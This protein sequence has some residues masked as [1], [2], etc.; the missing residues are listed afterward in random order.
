ML[1]SKK[2]FIISSSLFVLLLLLWGIYFFS[3]KNNAS[4]KEKFVENI[5]P[6]E[7][8]SD[9]KIPKIFALSEEPVLGP[10]F[11]KNKSNLKYYSKKTG[12]VFQIEFDGSEKSAISDKE[13]SGLS[14]IFWSPEKN[15]VVSEFFVEGGLS[16]SSYDYSERMGYPLGK[17]FGNINW[18]NNQKILYTYKTADG[19]RT[20]NIADFDGKNWLKLTDL[21]FINI[22][23]E[24]IPL[25][26]LI[27]F[28]NQ[29][30]GFEE[31]TLKTISILGGEEK[32]IFQ[33]KF[34]ADYLWSP[35]GNS[36]LISHLAEKGS[37][38]IQL[39]LTNAKGGEY[40]NLAFPTLVSKCVW[41]HDSK[42][43]FC[44]LPGNI[45]D[46]IVM[47]NDY[48]A[49]KFQ[50]TDIFW[51]INTSNGEKDRIIETKELENLPSIDVLN[52]FLNEDESFIF[53]TNKKDGKLYRLEL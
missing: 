16:Y 49:G 30:N 32:I 5:L 24:P 48:W 8:I 18:Y 3:F 11:V 37:A 46:G 12:Q 44:A 17:N 13:L 43:I 41:S 51:K 21:N 31:T 22:R 29:G 25:T 50:T 38:K 45:P 15:R 6:V 2:I 47:P 34:G 26:G 33:G 36:L 35:D 40:K 42:N 7:I 10:V 23:I 9:K 4:N 27:S 1:L 20:L 52:P 19:K 39:A 28:W 53:F 14:S